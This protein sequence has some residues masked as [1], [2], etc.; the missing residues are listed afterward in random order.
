MYY[1]IKSRPLSNHLV[2]RG[3]D[4]IKVVPNKKVPKF[5]VFLFV[6][7]RELREEITRYTEA[8]IKEKEESKRKEQKETCQEEKT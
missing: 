1:V 3:F 2:R 6:D 5:S 4:L 8:R 7:S